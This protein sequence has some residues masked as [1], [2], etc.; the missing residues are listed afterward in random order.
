MSTEFNR[1]FT[2][3]TEVDTNE[4]DFCL[5]G[6]RPDSTLARIRR[7]PDGAFTL[8]IDL[9]LDGRPDLVFDGKDIQI[10][11]GLAIA[12]DHAPDGRRS[13]WLLALSGADP[14]HQARVMLY[15]D[16]DFYVYLID[17]DGDGKGDFGRSGSV[18]RR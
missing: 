3:V 6:H 14:R 4:Q 13:Q 7:S 8:T 5:P 12:E 17:V 15:R 18:I 9:N 2:G 11:S 10:G 16:G 1:H